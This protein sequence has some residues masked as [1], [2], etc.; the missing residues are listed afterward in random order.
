MMM[1]V[2]QESPRSVARTAVVGCR[3]V[4]VDLGK[5]GSFDPGN[6]A[7]GPFQRHCLLL[8]GAKQDYFFRRMGGLLLLV[9]LH[10]GY[11][12]EQMPWPLRVHKMGLCLRSL[13]ALA[14]P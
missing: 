12:Y 2:I 13:E 6:W 4:R 11:R 8:S 9:A 1:M 10:L 3:G 14:G 5:L 7:L